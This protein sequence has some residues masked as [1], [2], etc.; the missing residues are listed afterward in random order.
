MGSE[1]EDDR[2][3]LWLKG[4]EKKNGEYGDDSLKEVA[5]KM[6]SFYKLRHEFLYLVFFSV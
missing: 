2:A 5:D 1:Y 6:V 4:R 3:F